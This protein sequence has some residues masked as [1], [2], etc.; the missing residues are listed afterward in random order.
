MSEEEFREILKEAL[1]RFFNKL[2][3][4]IAPESV[5]M[6]HIM[7]AEI[8]IYYSKNCKHFNKCKFGYVCLVDAVWSYS[9]C[10]A[11]LNLEEEGVIV[12]RE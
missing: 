4:G 3:Q 1:E 6:E 7:R 9:I 11:V 5:N 8:L 10:E 12:W 2:K